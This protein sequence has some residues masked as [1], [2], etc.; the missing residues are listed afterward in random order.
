M[1]SILPLA[2][3]FSKI[4][5]SRIKAKSDPFRTIGIASVLGLSG[6]ISCIVPVLDPTMMNHIADAPITDIRLTD[7]VLKRVS[8]R[9]GAWST[10]VIGVNISFKKGERSGG[11]DPGQRSWK[12]YETSELF[13]R[14]G[15][16]LASTANCSN[17]LTEQAYSRIL[18]RGNTNP[19]TKEL[20]QR[21]TAEE[22][23]IEAR[24]LIMPL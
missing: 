16:K 2:L 10:C 8:S 23:H 4:P 15:G 20:T 18:S 22:K 6:I 13:A 24:V 19:R 5:R 7:I 17:C 14:F 12:W 21:P 11:E 9:L 3:R 1:E